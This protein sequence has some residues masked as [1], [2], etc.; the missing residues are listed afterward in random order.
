MSTAW[1]QRYQSLVRCRLRQSGQ[2]SSRIGDSRRP[3]IGHQPF[4]LQPIF[5]V[6]RREFRHRDLAWRLQERAEIFAER[7]HAARTPR[8]ARPE[9]RTEVFSLSVPLETTH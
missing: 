9:R 8:R 5:L 7:E 4:A 1:A 6:I 3:A 2:L